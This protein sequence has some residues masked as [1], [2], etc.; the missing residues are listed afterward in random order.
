MFACSHHD[1]IHEDGAFKSLFLAMLPF[2]RTH[3]L[4]CNSIDVNEQGT[5]SPIMQISLNIPLPYVP[6]YPLITLTKTK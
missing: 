5:P 3:V 4:L 6:K 2:Y 1:K